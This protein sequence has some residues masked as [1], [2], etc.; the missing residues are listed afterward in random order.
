MTE[1]TQLQFDSLV[2][3]IYSTLMAQDEMGIGEMGEAQEEAQRIV[4]EWMDENNITFKN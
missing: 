1:M 2:N 4:N 3:G